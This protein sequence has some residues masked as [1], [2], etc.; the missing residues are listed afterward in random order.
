MRK[1]MISWVLCVLLLLSSFLPVHAEEAAY[2][3]STVEEFLTFAENCRLDSYSQGLTVYLKKSLDLT[4]VPFEGIPVFAG[5]FE[6]GGYTISGL[7]LTA[8][9]SVQGLFRYLTAD[10]VVR[11]LSVAGEF[12]PGGSRNKVGAIAGENAGQI[13]SCSFSG[14]VSGGD[15]VGGLVGRSREIILWAASPVKMTA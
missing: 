6:G 2:S 5:T 8:D 10:A 7:S 15:S 13:I 11:N 9:G 1:R 4:G 3:I 14:S 12:H